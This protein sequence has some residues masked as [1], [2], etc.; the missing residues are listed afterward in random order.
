L[1][2][3]TDGAPNP[4]ADAQIL[5]AAADLSIGDATVEDQSL[6]IDASEEPQLLDAGMADALTA[7][8]ASVEHPEPCALRCRRTRQICGADWLNDCDAACADESLR[9]CFDVRNTCSGVARCAARALAWDC[10]QRCERVAAVCDDVDPCLA[11][12]AAAMLSADPLPRIHLE[13]DQMCNLLVNADCET[14]RQC[15][16]EDRADAYG[17]AHGEDDLCGLYDGCGSPGCRA[18]FLDLR[19]A[20]G[21]RAVDCAVEQLQQACLEARDLI[22]RCV[23]PYNPVR[24]ASEHFCLALTA[25][26]HRPLDRPDP[27]CVESSMLQGT[28]SAQTRERHGA[29]VACRAERACD[30]FRTCLEANPGSP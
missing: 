21:W 22:D 28:L 23:G 7:L 8:D 27:T 25:C 5:D 24:E 9:D 17:S 3:C 15:T 2:A 20:G 6:R 18:L 29:R 30:A 10:H 4:T 26:S 12:C 14:L 19:D 11:E 13:R 16:Q 1:A